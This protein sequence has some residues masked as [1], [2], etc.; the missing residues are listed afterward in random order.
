MTTKQLNIKSRSYYFYSDLINLRNFDE[1]NLKLDQKSWK[2]FDIYYLGYVDKK[3]EWHVSSV[4]QL[5]FIVNRVY[6]M[7]FEERYKISVDS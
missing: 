6:G 2:D 3:P 5:Y 1:H 4:N 7:I